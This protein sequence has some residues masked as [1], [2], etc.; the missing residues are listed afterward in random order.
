NGCLQG[1]STL[2]PSGPGYEVMRLK[3]NRRFGHPSLIAFIE[4]LGK[5]AR[6]AKLG[7]VVVGDLSQPRGGPTPS[8]HRSH[9]TGLDADIGYLAPPG[10]H[11]GHVSARDRERLSPPAVVDLQS[12]DTTSAWRAW[13]PRLLAI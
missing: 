10:L 3:R 13:T 5:G 9:Q 1:A 12:H 6:A 7:V 8:G 2:R 4:R 11:A